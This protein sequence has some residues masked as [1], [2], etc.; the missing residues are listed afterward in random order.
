MGAGERRDVQRW[1]VR[2]LDGYSDAYA[3][4]QFRS[5]RQ[6]FRWLAAEDGIADP[7]AGLRPPK[8]RE[9][10][11]PV[12]SSVELSR[13]ERACRGNWFEDRRDA[14]I[15][16]VLLATGIRLAEL[17]GL[18]YHPFDPYRSDVDLDAREIKVRGK[19][20]KGRTV[21]ITHEAAH[22]LDRYLRARARHPLAYLPQLWLGANNKC[23]LGRT[24]IYQIVVRRG[25][26]AGVKVY[27][28]RF[29]H[30]FSHSWLDRGGAEG[31][32]MVLN[33]WSSP[34]MLERYGA[35]LA[36]PAPAATTT[37]LWTTRSRQAPGTGGASRMAA[38][39][40][41]GTLGADGAIFEGEDDDRTAPVPAS[42]SRWTQGRSCRDRLVPAAPGGR[43]QV[44]QDDPDLHRGGGV[45][46]RRPP[47]APGG[48]DRLAAGGQA[49]RPG[50]DGLA[51][52]PVQ[53]LLRQ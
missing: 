38:A 23:P 21:R 22:R 26:E 17:T 14:A 40:V 36:A 47:A 10:P 16:A 8:V 9:K 6:F 45:V 1:T 49:G 37:S 29:R 2:L 51:A 32:L 3:Y 25:E 41:Q 46:R 52:G 42:P 18:R 34:Q 24:G 4:Q 27:P 5:L 7:M 39:G 31:D 19:G 15:I 44:G 48:Q 20:G 12:F 30:H 13:L 53:R 28:H 35:A 43:G 33:G 50:V 11:V